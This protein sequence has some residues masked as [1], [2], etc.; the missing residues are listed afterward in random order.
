MDIKKDRT[1][2]KAFAKKINVIQQSTFSLARIKKIVGNDLFPIMFSI[3][4]VFRVVKSQDY[5]VMS[6]RYFLMHI[7]GVS[8]VLIY[9]CSLMNK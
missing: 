1:G 2:M 7:C 8:F 9:T 4:F 5:R 6:Q 3:G